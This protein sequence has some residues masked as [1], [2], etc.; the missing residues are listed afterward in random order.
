MVHPQNCTLA[1]KCSGTGVT[2][3]GEK[4]EF[5]NE[6]KTLEEL[7]LF[8]PMLKL[9]DRQG[10]QDEKLL[11]AE[12]SDLIGRRLHD[13]DIMGPEVNKQQQTVNQT[14]YYVAVEGGNKYQQS[15]I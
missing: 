12:I 2:S 15:K 9:Q 7:D 6:G 1:D 11:N 4:E 10:N 14:N 3:D 5:I 8:M 13:F